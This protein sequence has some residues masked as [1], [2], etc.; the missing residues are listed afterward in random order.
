MYYCETGPSTSRIA[1]DSVSCILGSP[2]AAWADRRVGECEM[3]VASGMKV[4]IQY[5]LKR[6]DNTVIDANV[7][8]APL[9]YVHGFQQIIPGLEKALEGM[10]VGEG[11]QITVSPEEGYGVISQKAFV[12]VKKE[13][14]PQQAQD[15]LR[16][17]AYVR[18]RDDS[19]NVFHARVAE[20]KDRTVLLDFNHPLAGETL[21]FEVK[22]LDIQ[23]P[24][25]D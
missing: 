9:T 19:G 12:E 18:G 1:F 23:E 3:R 4:S 11:R 6:D 2:T 10:A 16:V 20:I 15:A 14:V 17:D 13:Q 21:F 22:V 7:G 8:S 5:I 25:T 24:P